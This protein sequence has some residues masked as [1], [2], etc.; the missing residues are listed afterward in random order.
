MHL[1]GA[2]VSVTEFLGP[3]SATA[4]SEYCNFAFFNATYSVLSCITGKAKYGELMERMFYNAAQGARKKDEKAIA[5]LSA[6]NQLY[7][8]D[9]SSNAMFDMQVY[10]PC[11]PTACCPVNAVAVVPE[12]IRG[13]LLRD[14]DKN[15]YVMAY[16]P[17][18]L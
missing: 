10:A 14:S 3:V 8:T 9:V 6:P 11:Y 13:M 4:E 12:F 5:Y 17:C 7:A 18:S 1:T 16:G 15:V 2:P